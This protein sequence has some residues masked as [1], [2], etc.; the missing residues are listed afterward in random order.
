MQGSELI[1]L[2][3]TSIAVVSTPN[4]ATEKKYVYGISGIK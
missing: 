2:I 4:E 3:K 1:E